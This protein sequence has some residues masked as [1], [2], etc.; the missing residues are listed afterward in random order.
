MSGFLTPEFGISVLMPVHNAGNYL[1]VAVNSVLHQ[2]GVQFELIIIDD[3]STDTALSQLPSDTR[4]RRLSS[5]VRG[6]VAAL[7]LGL[8]HARFPY[9]ARMDAD[10]IAD[11]KRLFT[12]LN[13]FQKN[14]ELDICGTKVKLFCDQGL[15]GEGYRHYQQWINSLCTPTDIEREF[16]V[17]SP[18][19]HPS[20]MLRREYLNSLG[21]Y[22]DSEWPEDYDL[23]CRALI[24]NAKFG[25]P[26]EPDLLLWRDHQG[27]LSRSN[28]RYGKQMFLRCK[29][30]YLTKYLEQK[31]IDSC[32]IL[33]AGP[34]G[35]KLHDYL[36]QN[37]LQVKGFIDINMKLKG[38]QKRS[39]AV[40]I[41]APEPNNSQL[42]EHIDQSQSIIIAAVSSRGAR[43]KIRRHLNNS[44]L[45]EQRD[46]I[47]AA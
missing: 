26:D 21:G 44:T 28:I 33:G 7:N 41:L 24:A 17:E 35:L 18:I 27:R 34:T 9:I 3:S 25:K 37:G 13:H 43:E 46:Y 11:P 1:D 19:P 38:R 8:K 5:P 47:F 6:I 2:Y 16:F 20:V 23:W 10:D 36:E 12:Q 45:V 40:K 30:H 29:A 32:T 39:K 14:P 22:N 31:G 4:I 42:I 15:I